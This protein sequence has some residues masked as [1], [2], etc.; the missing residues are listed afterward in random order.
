MRTYSTH[1]RGDDRLDIVTTGG[2]HRA[3]INGELVAEATRSRSA[4]IFAAMDVHKAARAEGR[5]IGD[6]TM[7]LNTPL[8]YLDGT[9]L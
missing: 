1:L 6:P 2:T 7:R 5:T 3:Y 8:E 4:A 9:P